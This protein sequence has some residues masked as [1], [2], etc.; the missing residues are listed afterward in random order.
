[1]W[2][3]SKIFDLNRR[4]PHRTPPAAAA[5]GGH[6]YALLIGISKYK[7]P[8]LS[9]Q[10]ADADATVFGNCSKAS[11]AAASRRKSDAPYR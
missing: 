8:D 6:T 7:L 2:V 4:W 9:L 11:A 10:F 3:K 1:M 5:P